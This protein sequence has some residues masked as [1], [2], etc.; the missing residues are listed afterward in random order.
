MR[1]RIG[2]GPHFPP[3]DLPRF[4][5]KRKEMRRGWDSNPRD[6]FKPPT[7]FPVALLRPTRTPLRTAES[8]PDKFRAWG[9]RRRTEPKYSL[10]RGSLDQGAQRLSIWTARAGIITGDEESM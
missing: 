8:L 9:R 1:S 3:P 7:R 4:A 10:P 2:S 5:R 6:G